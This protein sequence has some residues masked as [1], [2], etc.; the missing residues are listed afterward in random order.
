MVVVV[1]VERIS[2]GWGFD[3][4]PLSLQFSRVDVRSSLSSLVHT[5]S[6][7]GRT[8]PRAIC[9]VGDRGAPIRAR[10]KGNGRTRSLESDRPTELALQSACV[11]SYCILYEHSRTSQDYRRKKKSCAWQ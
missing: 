3:Q 8:Q 1:V 7:D 6:K 4:V 9:T 5:R 10:K 2:A 11:F